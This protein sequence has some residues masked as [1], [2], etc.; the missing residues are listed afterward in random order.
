MIIIISRSDPN[1][2]KDIRLVNYWPFDA[3]VYDVIGIAHLYDGVNSSFSTDRFNRANRA[4]SLN[5]GYYKIP[6]GVYFD[7]SDFTFTCWVKVK[8]RVNFARIFEVA[9][10][11]NMDAVLITVHLDGR[12]VFSYSNDATFTLLYYSNT[13]LALN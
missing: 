11:L 9:N 3:N 7:G 1:F 12:L 2:K 10:G 8:Q 6:S 4:L 13:V 5:S